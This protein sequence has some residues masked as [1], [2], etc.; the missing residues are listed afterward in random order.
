MMSRPNDWTAVGRGLT[1]WDTTPEPRAP[2]HERDPVA[3]AREQL[4]RRHQADRLKA[5][6]MVMQEIN[7]SIARCEALEA[8]VSEDLEK[9]DS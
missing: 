7:E 6:R 3:F 9:K 8:A 2:K 4:H 5:A 1:G